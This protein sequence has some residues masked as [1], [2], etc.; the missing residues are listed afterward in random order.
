VRLYNVALS[1]NQIQELYSMKN[2]Y[3]CAMGDTDHPTG[4]VH[5]HDNFIW[6]ANN[7]QVEVTIKAML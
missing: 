5:V 4:A 7:K 3:E 1:S 6:P 2:Q